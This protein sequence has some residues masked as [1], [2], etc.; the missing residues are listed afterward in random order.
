MRFILIFLTILLLF[1]CGDYGYIQETKQIQTESFL[2]FKGD[3]EGVL[4]NIDG[5]KEFVPEANQDDFSDKYIYKI[6]PGTHRIK[7]YKNNTLIIDEKFYIG[8]Q[9]TKEIIVR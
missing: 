5:E 6:T 1:T 9:E 3:L 8:N 4:V 7:V 2:S